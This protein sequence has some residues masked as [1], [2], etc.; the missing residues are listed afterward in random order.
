MGSDLPKVAR[1]LATLGFGAKSRW[2]KRLMAVLEL[3][4]LDVT[5]SRAIAEASRQGREEREE[6][7]PNK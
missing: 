2:D 7:E 6:E 3:S 5:C 4:G 1:R